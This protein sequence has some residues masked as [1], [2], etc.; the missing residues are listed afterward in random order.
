[1]YLGLVS[2][3]INAKSLLTLLRYQMVKNVIL[4]DNH[5]QSQENFWEMNKTCKKIL[6]ILH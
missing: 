5:L 1:M 6:Y 2:T 3:E 4:K